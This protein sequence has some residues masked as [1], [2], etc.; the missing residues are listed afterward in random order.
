ML[1]RT[2]ENENEY[3]SDEGKVAQQQQIGNDDKSQKK[4]L[5]NYV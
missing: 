3:D 5:G 1:M 2:Y 4:G